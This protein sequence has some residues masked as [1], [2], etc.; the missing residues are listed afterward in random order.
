MSHHEI[1]FVLP[2]SFGMTQRWAY[3]IQVS[4]TQSGT[5]QRVSK[6]QGLL[7]SATLV[8]NNKVPADFLYL[9]NWFGAVGGEE[10][11][12][13]IALPL[14][15]DTA[16]TAG[17]AV[18]FDDVNIGTGDGATTAFQLLKAYTF[19][20]V[21]RTRI[22]RKPRAG[23]VKCGV[24]GVET[25]AFTTDTVNGVVTFDTA[26][27]NGQSVTA[28]FEFLI[29]MRVNGPAM[30]AVIPSRIPNAGYVVSS[31]IALIEDRLA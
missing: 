14:D 11:S 28:G 8:Y 30:E 29:A 25:S 9:L 18:A 10:D 17:A 16:K 6:W 27:P 5:D 13:L 12:F 15:K 3:S 21:T 23:T 24:N 20:T 1:E 19:G 31:T 4:R 2:P 26:P 7:H 22:I